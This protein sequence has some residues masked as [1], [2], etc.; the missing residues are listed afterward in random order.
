MHDTAKHIGRLFFER[1]ARPGGMV[2]ELG[3][4]D[5]NGSLREVCPK[6]L[7]YI[8]LDVQAGP[9]VDLVASLARCC[10]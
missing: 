9:G 1:Y 3:A 4:F 2:I 5:V 6:E 8:G 10:R 7:T